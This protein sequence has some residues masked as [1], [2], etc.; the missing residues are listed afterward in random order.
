MWTATLEHRQATIDFTRRYSMKF[1][2]FTLPHGLLAAGVLTLAA[3]G[4]ATSAPPPTDQMTVAKAA[5]EAAN[6]GGAQGYA[7]TELRMAN[8][9]LAGAQRAMADKNYMSALR[10]AQ[11]AQA[12]AQLAVSKTQS[13]KAHQ[14]ADEA[15]LAARE[16]MGA[17]TL[18]L[19]PGGT[20]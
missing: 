11:Q 16:Q 9:K 1:I 8:E 20:Q 17:R 2:Q 10:L 14:A 7:A 13:A 5:V 19:G 15:Q 12:D 6:A 18:P 3:V 4:C